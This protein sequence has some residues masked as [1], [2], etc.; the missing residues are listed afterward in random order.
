MVA[1][2]YDLQ[3][4][5]TKQLECLELG[6]DGGHWRLAFLL[7]T[8]PDPPAAHQADDVACL[9]F[10]AQKEDQLY[11]SQSAAGCEK[12]TPEVSSRKLPPLSDGRYGGCGG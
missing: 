4:A 11:W 7:G 1:L 12:A 5:V 3:E 10:V 8:W 9:F 6:F 2:G